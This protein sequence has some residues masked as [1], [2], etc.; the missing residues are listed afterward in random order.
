MPRLSR[1]IEAET[2]EITLSRGAELMVIS[3][4]D[5]SSQRGQAEPNLHIPSSIRPGV[6]D[7]RLFARHFGCFS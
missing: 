4:P 6:N 5:G 3:T 2:A 1:A 7:W